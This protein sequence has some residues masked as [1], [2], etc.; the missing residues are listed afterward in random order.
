MIDTFVWKYSSSDRAV[1]VWSGER[2]AAEYYG[3]DNAVL[4]SVRVK[5]T[6]ALHILDP[7]YVFTLTYRGKL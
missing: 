3:N 6:G 5:P 4:Y 2:H 7:K 1:A